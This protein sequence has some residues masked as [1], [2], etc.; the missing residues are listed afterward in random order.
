VPSS[1]AP[2]VQARRASRASIRRALP[3]SAD[4]ADRRADGAAHR[5]LPG[6]GPGAE[7]DRRMRR[8]ESECHAKPAAPGSATRRAGLTEMNCHIQRTRAWRRAMTGRRAGGSADVGHGGR[9]APHQ[10]RAWQAGSGPAR[11]ARRRRAT[12]GRGSVA[13]ARAGPSPRAERLSRARGAAL[14]AQSALMAMPALGAG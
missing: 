14:H 4:P 10:A 2:G 6:A 9:P 1:W 12:G 8:I 13:M 11:R 5:W 7:A 3:A